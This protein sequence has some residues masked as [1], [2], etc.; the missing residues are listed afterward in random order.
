M[1]SRYKQL[2]SFSKLNFF[3]ITEITTLIRQQDMPADTIADF[4]LIHQSSV[5]GHFVAFFPASRFPT[6]DSICAYFEHVCF[7]HGRD[8]LPLSI[9][10]DVVSDVTVIICDGAVWTDCG[11]DSGLIAT[12]HIEP[13]LQYGIRE[14]P[15]SS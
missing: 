4:E 2:F 3:Q 13:A 8:L 14:A 15:S 7:F 10:P 12:V 1:T 5:P 9:H 11:E 6:L